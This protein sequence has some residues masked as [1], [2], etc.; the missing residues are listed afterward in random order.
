MYNI[1]MK[2]SAKI[3]LQDFQERLE[4]HVPAEFLL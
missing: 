2:T 4:V 3:N 1:R